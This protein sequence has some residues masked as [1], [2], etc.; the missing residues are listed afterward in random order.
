V[1]AETAIPPT[2]TRTVLHR[3]MVNSTRN[4]PSY[5]LVPD[6]KINYDEYVQLGNVLYNISEPDNV[7]SKPRLTLPST[8]LGT[9]PSVK[10]LENYRI[11]HE[12]SKSS[13]IGFFSKVLDLLGF[14]LNASRKGAKSDS[15]A[16]TVASMS[17]STFSPPKEFLDAVAKDSAVSDQLRNSPDKSAFLITGVVVAT[18]VEFTSSTS[19]EAEHEGSLG[20]GSQGLSFGPSGSRA[21]KTV[22]DVSYTDA[23]PVVLAYRVQKLLLSEDGEIKNQ[24]HTTGAYFSD[25]VEKMTMQFDAE[26]AD[27]DTEDFE[28]VEDIEED[29]EQYSLYASIGQ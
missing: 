6:E 9:K 26:F 10:E 12:A 27:F 16:Y 19:R 24:Q 15:E 18:G 4:S 22:L 8:P 29:G 21:R 7:L 23:G 13:K 3:T 2:N 25:D 14:G 1:K 5:F 28:K 17:I 11:S 20:I